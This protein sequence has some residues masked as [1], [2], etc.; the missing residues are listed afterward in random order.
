MLYKIKQVGESNCLSKK[1]SYLP[2]DILN[3]VEQLYKQHYFDFVNK[4]F[5]VTIEV[6]NIVGYK[7]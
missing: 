6:I 1:V 2:R 5:G 7:P 3:E 4:V